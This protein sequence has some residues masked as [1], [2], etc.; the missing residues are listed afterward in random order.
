M[1][2]NLRERLKE[3]MDRKHSCLPEVEERASDGIPAKAQGLKEASISPQAESQ[4]EPE[5]EKRYR[6]V[7]PTRIND[8]QG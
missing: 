5:P 3:V 8:P 7:P 1:L 4:T 2:K 6:T